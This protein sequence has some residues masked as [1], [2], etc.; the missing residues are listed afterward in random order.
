VLGTRPGHHTRVEAA[1]LSAQF[2]RDGL[3]KAN[4]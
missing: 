4:S 2:V 3:K 1:T